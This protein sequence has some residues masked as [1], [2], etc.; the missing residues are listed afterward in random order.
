MFH[1][2]S[3]HAYLWVTN[4]ERIEKKFRSKL[5]RFAFDLIIKV[6]WADKLSTKVARAIRMGM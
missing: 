5:S 4:Y 6:T 2:L 1:R 3:K